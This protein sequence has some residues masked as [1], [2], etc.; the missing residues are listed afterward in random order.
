M[1]VILTMVERPRPQPA[2]V[3]CANEA[4]CLAALLDETLLTV[5][6]KRYLN[7]AGP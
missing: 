1:W 5:N 3:T 2:A 4:D 6:S 7:E